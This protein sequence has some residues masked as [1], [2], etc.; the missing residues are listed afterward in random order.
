MDASAT[1]VYCVVQSSTKPTGSR[2][3]AGLPAAAPPRL[4][5]AG[6]SLWIVC[7]AVP[8]ASY[9]SAVLDASLRDL[10]WVG[11]IA[12]AHE[13]VV[14]HFAQQKNV[15]VVPMKLFTMFSS[16]DRA[17][18]EMRTR[19]REIL[20]VARRIT[21]CEEWGVRIA[22]TT[23]AARGPSADAPRPT[24]GAAFLAA[25]KEARD[26]A[27]A[28]ARA[29]AESAEHAYATLSAIARDARRR[30]DAPDGA[31]APPLLD[32]AFLVP[33]ARRSRFKAAARRLAA[34]GARTGTEITVTGPWPAYNF[35]QEPAG[36]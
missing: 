18:N 15:T 31:V 14:E 29:A 4:L 26:L 22:R 11:D 16:D 28:L 13:S 8:L 6:R 32:A 5:E 30:V 23:S 25:K 17:L 19:R 33:A 20:A 3:P 9:G 12:V 1:Y 35:V 7:A 2:T 24:S 21:G 36:S 34:A 27:H 10:K